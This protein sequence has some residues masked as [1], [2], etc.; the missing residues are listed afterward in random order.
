LTKLQK[1]EKIKR[2]VLFESGFEDKIIGGYWF[3]TI[4]CNPK[5]VKHETLPRYFVLSGVPCCCELWS[6]CLP[7]KNSLH[8][9]ENSGAAV[10][11]QV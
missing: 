2:A 5:G 4:T 6:V 1:N 7:E 3:G 11:R 9:D 10:N 8:G